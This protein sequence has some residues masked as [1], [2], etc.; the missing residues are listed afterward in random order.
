M[1]RVGVGDIR[2]RRGRFPLLRNFSSESA[3]GTCP[4]RT[5][6]IFIGFPL[7]VHLP[8]LLP[9]VGPTEVVLGVG[10]GPVARTLGRREVGIVDPVRRP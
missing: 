1:S 2:H 7:A 9:S 3:Q 6:K 5:T 8:A 10:T 4:G